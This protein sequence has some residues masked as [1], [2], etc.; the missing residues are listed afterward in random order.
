[1]ALIGLCWLAIGLAWGPAVFLMEPGDQSL[2]A[3]GAALVLSIASFL[4]W[5]AV[6]P[7]I[8]RWCA[9]VDLGRRPLRDGALLAGA[10]L[11]VVPLVTFAGRACT[12]LAAR[13][14]GIAIGPGT[15]ADWLRAVT[16]TSLFALPTALAVVAVGLVLAASRR[17]SERDRLL[18]RA[19]LDAL[20]A[21]L[22]PHFLFNSLG[23][24][25]QLAHQSPDAAERAIG[26]LAD[27]LRATLAEKRQLR[28]LA[29]EI[30]AVR[31]HLDLHAAL[32]GG[33]GLDL[34]IDAEAWLAQVPSHILTPL[35]ENATT[36]GS[37]SPDG[38][39][40][41]SS[42][43][44]RE[45]GWLTVMLANPCPA[46]AAPSSG[47]GSGIG[48]VRERLAMLCGPSAAVTGEREGTV[49]LVI[50]RMPFVGGKTDD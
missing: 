31:D 50:V 14:M 43:A 26:S 29:D 47:L 46:A 27:I 6:T 2:A 12:L 40:T 35:V 24:I 30:S 13:I 18:A 1:M 21:E 38:T 25:A 49:Y 8:L 22:N 23:G 19:R 16:I 7:A 9:L 10:M 11:V 20:R 34:R 15:L 17:A 37:A 5:M 42:E 33:I 32:S 4:P 39:F 45:D 41:I 28:P 44:V 36:H 3:F 48:H